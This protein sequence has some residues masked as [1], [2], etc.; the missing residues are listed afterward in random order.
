MLAVLQAME[1]DGDDPM[2]LRMLIKTQEALGD[3]KGALASYIRLHEIYKVEGYDESPAPFKLAVGD[4][5]EVCGHDKEALDWF[6]DALTSDPE[7]VEPMSDSR[8]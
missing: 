3:S 6:Q 2:V 8:T 7:C 1:F 4:L 5:C